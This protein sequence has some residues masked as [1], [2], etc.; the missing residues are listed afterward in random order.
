MIGRMPKKISH[1]G[2]IL[3]YALLYYLIWES[4]IRWTGSGFSSTFNYVKS[5]FSPITW[6]FAL[7]WDKDPVV[8]HLWFLFA[9]LRCYILFYFFLKF[10]LEK[11][12]PFISAVCLTGT[13]ILQTAGLQ[14]CYYRN[15]WLYGMGFFMAGYYIA[16]YSKKNLDKKLVYAAMAAGLVLS[17]IGGIRFPKEQIYLGTIILLLSSFYW[18]VTKEGETND[19]PIA[20]MFAEIGLKYGTLIYVIHWSLKECLIKVDKMFAFARSSLVQWL[21]PIILVFLSVVS[22][23]ILYHLIDKI[24]NA[25]RKKK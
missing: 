19:N 21:S 16:A 12:A 9:L 15:G 3:F 2:K 11:Y 7:L 10:R 5:V 24:S 6:Y 17:I 8:G 20:N 25:V 4:F 22:C 13:L 1:I 23:V 14:N 18:A